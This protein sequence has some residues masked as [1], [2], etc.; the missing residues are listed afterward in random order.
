LAQTPKPSKFTATSFSFYYG[1]FRA[2]L[3]EGFAEA[4]SGMIKLDTEEP[5]IF[6]GFDKWLYTTKARTDEITKQNAGG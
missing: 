6:E 5:A 4:G 1:Y 3:N 2:A